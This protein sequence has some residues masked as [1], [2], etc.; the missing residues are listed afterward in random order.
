MVALRLEGLADPAGVASGILTAQGAHG[1]GDHFQS[2]LRG[3]IAIVAAEPHGC[4]KAGRHSQLLV[5][6]AI[7]LPGL[8][9]KGECGPLG[10]GPARGAPP[11][12]VTVAVPT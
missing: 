1:R 11:S 7:P 12:T 3:A 9:G 4:E 2:Q 5:Y 10:Q 8:E 6:E